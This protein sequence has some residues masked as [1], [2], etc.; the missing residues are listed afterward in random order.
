MTISS[1]K[2]VLLIDLENQ[3]YETKSFPDLHKYLGGVGVG[4]K[5]LEY[6]YDR[7]PLVMSVGP[8]N[9]FFPYASKTS[10][11][12]KNEGNIE[13]IYIGG[14]LSFRIKF[15]GY[16][17]IVLLGTSD[18][19]VNLAIDANQ[20]KFL[21]D[22]QEITAS[23]LPG[24]S[25]L[26]R[27]DQTGLSLDGYFYS[28]EDLF[29]KKLYSQ[30]IQSIVITGTKTFPVNQSEKYND[31]YLKILNKQ[32]L[33]TQPRD[34]FP[35]CSGCPI[36]CAKSKMGEIGGNVL[37]HSLVACAYAEPIYSDIGTVFSCLSI[38]GYDYKHEDIENLSEYIDIVLK[39]LKNND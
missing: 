13:D 3:T 29:N 6:Y 31:L 23:I 33:V 21:S 20:V 17:A 30:F 5:L 26:L 25:S 16:D 36:G 18:K 38:L 35:S 2:Q 11:V 37:V 14:T 8:L 28:P 12:L 4:L 1:T 24:R 27:R 15:A 22:Y 10:I 9:G 7:N 34:S 39:G 32:H 19:N